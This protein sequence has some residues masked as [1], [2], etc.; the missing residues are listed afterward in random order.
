[1]NCSNLLIA[2][3]PFIVAILAMG[4]QGIHGQCAND[5]V[6]DDGGDSDDRDFSRSILLLPSQ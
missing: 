1:M 2:T 5:G 6:V 3:N 4:V